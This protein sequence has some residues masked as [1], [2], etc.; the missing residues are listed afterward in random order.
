MKFFIRFAILVLIVAALLGGLVWTIDHS[1]AYAKISSWWQH[2]PG[3]YRIVEVSDGDT[4]IVD[5]AGQK[6]TIRLIGVDTPE[7]HHPSKPVQCFGREASDFAKQQLSGQFVRLEA[8][9][10]SGN[11]DRYKRL[12]RFVYTE[13]DQLF[14]QQLIEQGFGFAVLAFP[15]TKMETFTQ[16]QLYAEA[17]SVGLWSSCA[18]EREPYFSTGP[19]SL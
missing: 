2:P 4:V 14:N 5:M 7:T 9:P 3:T 17:K 13:D 8:D 11:R 6:E 15:H 12:L 18:I 16:A 19:A 10:L 1:N